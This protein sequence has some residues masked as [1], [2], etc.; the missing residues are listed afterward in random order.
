RDTSPAAAAPAGTG[1]PLPPTAVAPVAGSPRPTGRRLA[2]VRRKTHA[3]A[4]LRVAPDPSPLPND[5]AAPSVNRAVW[6]ESPTGAGVRSAH[7]VPALPGA[8]PTPAPSW[9]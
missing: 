6:Q 1:T 5:P 3:P 9:S 8:G 7:S 2:T 4:S